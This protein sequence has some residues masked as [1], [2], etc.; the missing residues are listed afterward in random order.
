MTAV[1]KVLAAKSGKA[2]VRPGDVVFPDPDYVMIHDG[3]VMGAAVVRRMIE[4]G[5]DAVGAFVAWLIDP[6]HG[7]TVAERQRDGGDVAVPLQARHIAILF[8]RFISFGDDVTR[9]YADALDATV[10]HYRDAAQ[11]EAAIPR[12]KAQQRADGTE[13]L[14]HDHGTAGHQRGKERVQ[15]SSHVAR[16]H[17]VQH[18]HVLVDRQAQVGDVVFDPDTVLSAM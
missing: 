2:S 3:V 6:A 14:A 5:A 11:L 4:G 10:Y 18:P 12:E 9:V 17:D 13:R 1:E 16:G 8:R 15:Q 7:W